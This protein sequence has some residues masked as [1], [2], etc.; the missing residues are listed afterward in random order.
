MANL[1]RGEVPFKARGRDFYLQYTTREI[2]EAQTA[3]G[4][5]RP[6][7][8]QADTLEEVAELVRENGQPKLDAEGLEIYRKR[9]VM[10]DAVERQRRMIA[11][12]EACLMNPDPE[13]AVIFLR[14]GLGPWQ[15]AAN[16]RL[17]EEGF[18]DIVRALGLNEIKFLHYKAI[19]F[20]SYLKSEADEE[21]GE[22]KVAGVEPVSSI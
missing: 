5:H 17:S 13:A 12:F 14:I 15:R 1:N 11:A 7:P 18:Q 20:G 2:A 4:F 6:D 3:L 22:G 9:R 19:S 21:E 16:A 10:V 8:Y